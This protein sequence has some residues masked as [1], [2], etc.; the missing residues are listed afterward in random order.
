MTLIASVSTGVGLVVLGSG[1]GCRSPI[2]QRGLRLD[3]P[4]HSTR[5]TQTQQQTKRVLTQTLALTP[6]NT[7]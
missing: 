2:G 7:L 6:T 3:Q 5:R 1:P 4:L